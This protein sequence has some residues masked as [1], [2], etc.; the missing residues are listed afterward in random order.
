MSETEK[1]LI[2][3][4]KKWTVRMKKELEGTEPYGTKGDEFLR[5]IRAYLKDSGH[6]QNNGDP[7]RSFEAII[8]AWSWLE[9]GKD[10]GFLKKEYVRIK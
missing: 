5:N 10:L 4:T 6:F 7:V 1:K 9:I 2:E 3:E 8:W